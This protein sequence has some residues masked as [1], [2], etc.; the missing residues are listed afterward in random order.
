MNKYVFLGVIPRKKIKQIAYDYRLIENEFVYSWFG[1]NFKIMIT[2]KILC[3]W[4]HGSNVK[5]FYDPMGIQTIIFF[6]PPCLK[7]FRLIRAMNANNGANDSGKISI[8][9]YFSPIYGQTSIN[10][11]V[12]KIASLHDNVRHALAT[13]QTHNALYRY[14]YI[15]RYIL[16]RSNKRRVKR[17]KGKN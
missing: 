8:T 1:V 7:L 2:T 4:E 17:K 16:R 10:C 12:T 15:Y 6:L 5:I 3:V 11:N 14:L 13:F 9:K